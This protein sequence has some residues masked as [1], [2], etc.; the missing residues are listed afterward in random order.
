MIA[1]ILVVCLTL[2]FWAT[3][4]VAGR[5]KQ[6]R[7][8]YKNSRDRWVK[9]EKK[10]R[11]DAYGYYKRGKET[12][13]KLEA[14]T[15]DNAVQKAN[16]AGLEAEV[17]RLSGI[18]DRQAETIATL[19]GNIGEWTSMVHGK[20][21]EIAALRDELADANKTIEDLRAYQYGIRMS[22]LALFPQL[23]NAP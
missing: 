9:A 12:E 19:D 16:V 1:W 14:V 15:D 6:D 13:F 18:R 11:D 5:L 20:S 8:W 4:W 23:D 2:A 17:E 21:Q 7:E 10:A 3:C 22:I